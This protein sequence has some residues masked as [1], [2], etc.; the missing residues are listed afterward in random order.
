MVEIVLSRTVSCKAV[1]PTESNRAQNGSE[2]CRVETCLQSEPSVSNRTVCSTKP[3]PNMP[4]W[5]F[6]NVETVSR[7]CRNRVLTVSQRCPDMPNRVQTCHEGFVS[8]TVSNRVLKLCAETVSN[9]VLELCPE[10]VSNRVLNINY[11]IP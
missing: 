11:V 1:G 6:G 5:R 3:C 7:L 9:R 8:Q 2:A 4:Q 10:T